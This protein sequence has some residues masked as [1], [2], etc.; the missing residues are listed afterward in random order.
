MSLEVSFGNAHILDIIDRLINDILKKGELNF[1]PINY[2]IG[3]NK[4]QYTEMMYGME[5]K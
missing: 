5:K 3:A 1:V 4:R 2:N